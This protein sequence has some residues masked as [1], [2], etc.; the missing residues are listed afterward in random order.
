MKRLL[1]T[2]VAGI[3]AVMLMMNTTSVQAAGVQEYK[4][5]AAK[6]TLF[7]G[8]L[9]GLPGKRVIIKSFTFKP[10]FRTAW[11]YHP[12]HVFVYV[13]EGE[14]TMDV[15]GEPRKIVKAGELRQEPVGK[16]M[17]GGNTSTK[18]TKVVVF[19]IGDADKPMMIK[20]NTK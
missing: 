19:Q 20:A 10:G 9:D 11:H 2:S 7:D 12:A 17:S 4:P 3:C 16:V 1:I 5:K 6:K 8:S 14:L 15:K 13:I 18:L